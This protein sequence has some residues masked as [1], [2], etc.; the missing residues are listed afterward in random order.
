MDSTLKRYFLIETSIAGAFG[1]GL[2]AVITWIMFHG[3]PIIQIWGKGGL[4]LD[5]FPHTF[6]LSFMSA[7]MPSLLT[8]SRHLGGRFDAR[9]CVPTLGPAAAASRRGIILS[10][11]FLAI[12]AT[13]LGVMFNAAF[14]SWAFPN[15]MPFLE[16][17]VFKCLYGSFVAVCVATVALINVLH[18]CGVTAPPKR[19]LVG[20]R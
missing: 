16:M 8:R 4:V 14:L 10:A 12:V 6:L 7:L 3:H 13:V 17:I 2:G 15:G 20:A 19:M 9:A 18:Q 11:L 1:I 5:A